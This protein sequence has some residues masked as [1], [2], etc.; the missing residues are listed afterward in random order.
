MNTYP[1]ICIENLSFSFEQQKVLH[2]INLRV[3]QGE[4]LAVIG[5][6]GGGKTTLLRLLLGLLKPDKGTITVL[7]KSARASIGRIGYVPQHTAVQPDIPITVLDTVLMGAVRKKRQLF[8]YSQTQ[9]EKALLALERLGLLAKENKRFE[10]LSG[11]QKQRV[12]I[13][14]ALAGEP[15]LLLLDEP[16]A[17]VDPQGSFCVYDFLQNLAAQAGRT[18]ISVSHDLSILASHI[19]S[20]ACVNKRLFHSP[21]PRLNKQMLETLYGTHDHSCSMDDFINSISA[22]FGSELA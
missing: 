5:P 10:S 2:N 9:K 4:F 19:S 14:R 17:N 6:N 12:L 3:E 20:V 13:A 21:T 18:I 11:G 8:G 22:Q 16:T 7:G 15:D 1:A